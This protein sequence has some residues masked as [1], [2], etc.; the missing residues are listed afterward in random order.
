MM[1]KL[2]YQDKETV[3]HRLN[4]V[5]KLAWGIIPVILSLVFANPFCILAIF[6]P[7]V[8]VIRAAGIWREWV[9]ML[10]PTLWLGLSIIVINA[11]VS[12]NGE[13][14]LASAPFTLSVIGR[15]II[16]L[17]AIAYG[18]V[19]ALKLIVIISAFT[20]INLTVH[21]DDIMSVFLQMKFPSK[22]VLVTSLST[23]FIPCLVDD[24]ER[25]G[26][27]YRTRAVALDTG[28][29]LRKIK[30][31]AGTIIP[32]LTNSLDR[33]IQV[34]EAMEA[35]AFGTGQKR[36]FYK[37]LKM[38][39]FD[40]AVFMTAAV[41]PLITGIVLRVM[42]YGSYQFYPTLGG[43]SFS[44][45]E[46]ALMGITGLSLAIIIPFAFFRKRIAFD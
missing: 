25:I 11:L 27:A 29:W 20:F 12:Y 37:D 39:P 31:R 19:M 14:V 41:I 43:A 16:T 35:R 30:N 33:S 32:L 4:P 44:S 40:M 5:I 6:I 17:E 18:A 22:S 3:I 26:D 7:L 28:N 2:R 13:H 46:W 8:L 42:G 21:P 36:V 34:A 23:R 10:K 15:P 45:L 1:R 24:V 9:S 38:S